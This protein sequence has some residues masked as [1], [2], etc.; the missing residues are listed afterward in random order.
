MPT[1]GKTGIGFDSS[2]LP[3]AY[4]TGIGSENIIGRGAGAELETVHGSSAADVGIANYIELVAAGCG[5]TDA[6]LS[7]RRQ[8]HEY[9]GA[10]TVFKLYLRPGAAEQNHAQIDNYSAV[11]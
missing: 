7:I 9:R 10:C 5:R 3:G 2:F 6:Q 8:M 1:P 11:F 4:A